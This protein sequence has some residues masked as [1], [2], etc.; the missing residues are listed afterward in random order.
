VTVPAA[1]NAPSNG[2]TLDR[3]SNTVRFERDISANPALAFAAWTRPEHVALWWDATGKPLA[4]CEID[5]RVGGSFTFVV[6][7]HPEMP[8]AGVYREIVPN[9]RLVFDALGSVGRVTLNE[10]GAGTHMVVEI[11]CAS[12]EQLEQFVQMGVAVGTSAT[13]D[14]LVRHLGEIVAPAA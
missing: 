13:L 5:L 2:F 3:A 1:P 9:D 14:N 8:F 10:R 11:S 6:Q 12:S 4:R 7:D